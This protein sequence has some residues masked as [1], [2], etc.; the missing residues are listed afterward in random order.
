[1]KVTDPGK[2]AVLLVALVG[3][4]VLALVGS[5]TH[6]PSTLAAG[7]GL[8]GTVVGYIT[9]NGRLASRGKDPQPTIGYRT[10]P[11]GLEAEADA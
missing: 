1:M 5:L 11:G 9:G 10:N 8:T 6:D 7:V 3:G 4:L 2:L